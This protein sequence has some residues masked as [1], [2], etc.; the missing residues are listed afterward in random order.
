MHKI[1]SGFTGVCEEETLVEIAALSTITA[2][3][4]T[5]VFN[6]EGGGSLNLDTPLPGTATAVAAA[7]DCDEVAVFFAVSEAST[8][9]L[10]LRCTSDQV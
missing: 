9:A 10:R 2:G 6:T 1:L 5:S 7:A 8:T 4:E 3:G